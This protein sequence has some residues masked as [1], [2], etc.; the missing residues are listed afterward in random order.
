M[1][2]VGAYSSV[3]LDKRRVEKKLTKKQP[4][5]LSTDLVYEQLGNFNVIV[6]SSQVKSCVS[7]VLLLVDEPRSRQLRQ[8]DSHRTTS[9]S[10]SNQCSKHKTWYRYSLPVK[11]RL[12]CDWGVQTLWSVCGW[13][14]KLCDPLVTH[15]PYLTS[16]C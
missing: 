6:K 16:R 9:T 11:G 12:P 14:V 13:Q 15:W 7:I 4:H 1:S 5:Y 3:Q 8:Q 2:Y 10:L